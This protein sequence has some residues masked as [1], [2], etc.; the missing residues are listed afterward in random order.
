MTE[1]VSTH[2]EEVLVVLLMIIIEP[3]E[4]RRHARRSFAVPCEIFFKSDTWNQ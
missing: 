2:T 3:Q 4:K 1:A